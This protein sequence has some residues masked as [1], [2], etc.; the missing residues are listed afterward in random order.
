MAVPVYID[1]PQRVSDYLH[2]I[3]VLMGVVVPDPDYSANEINRLTYLMALLLDNWGGGGSGG[4][5][6]WAL[7][8]NNTIVTKDLG[9]TSNQDFNFISNNT[10]RGTVFKTGEFMWGSTAGPLARFHIIGSGISGSSINFYTQNNDNTH[11]LAHYDNGAIYRNGFVHSIP[12][13]NYSIT[14]W[15]TNAGFTLGSA[16]NSL[17]N[18]FI[19]YNAGYAIPNTA[20]EYNG[21]VIVGAYSVT[22][23]TTCLSVLVGN[24]AGARLAGTYSSQQ[25][26]GQTFLGYGT[27][28]YVTTGINNIAIGSFSNSVGATWLTTGSYSICI[29][30][31][32][33]TGNFT[34]VLGFGSSPATANNQIVFGGGIDTGTAF[35]YGYT[36]MYLGTGVTNPTINNFTIRG[37][38]VIGTDTS[39]A[40]YELALVPPR[41]TGSAAGGSIK[42]YYSPVGSAGTALNTPVAGYTLDNTGLST[43]VN[44]KITAL[45][46]SGSEIITVS[47]DG[48]VGKTSF[49][50]KGDLAVYDG[51]NVTV[52]AA[53]SNDTL[54]SYDSATATGFKTTAIG[55][56]AGTVCA[57]NDSRLPRIIV[58]A[59]DQ[60]VASTVAWTGTTAPSGTATLRYRWNRV[61]DVCVCQFRLDYTVAGSALTAV[62]INW[63][64]DMPNPGSISGWDNTDFGFS[65]SGHV[66]TDFTANS[67][68]K[69]SIA[70]VKK[71]GSGVYQVVIQPNTSQN[72][73]G[74]TATVVFN[75]DPS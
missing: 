30:S 52:L 29:G 33:T 74:C 35:Q 32:S 64:A 15:G 13:A 47:N 18:T 55:T 67:G 66:F 50:A 48:T 56:A 58:H 61:D 62:T 41:G 3:L 71:D 26:G 10:D 23:A 12:N 49:T 14:S 22:T 17:N 24:D 9:T 53:G 42:L 65:V 60:A 19:G 39:A 51:T 69:N 59:G 44:L 25:G 8:G 43:I 36:D 68:Q 75:T 37:T 21:N 54:L 73:V 72:A 7:D 16:S 70:G 4:G 63:P 27:G 1:E 11:S 6:F 38:S 2:Q 20:G 28:S 57:G 34:G 45:A 46:A 40:A 5:T 31:W